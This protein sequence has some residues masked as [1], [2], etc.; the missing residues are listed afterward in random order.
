[1]QMEIDP[2]SQFFSQSS[3]TKSGR[4]NTATLTSS[5]KFRNAEF[6]DTLAVDELVVPPE[7]QET[8]ADV[9]TKEVVGTESVDSH[10]SAH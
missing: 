8:S 3:R 2:S 1:M 9:A 10:I 4:A 7:S 5:L 6:C